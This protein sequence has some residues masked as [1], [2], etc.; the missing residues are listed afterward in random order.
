[1]NQEELKSERCRLWK[2]VKMSYALLQRVH[3]LCM[4]IKAR[5][6][7]DK[8][9]WE[10]CDYALAMLDGRARRYAELVSGK[11]EEGKKKKRE[12]SDRPLTKEQIIKIA[13]E[14]GITLPLQ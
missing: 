2:E 1:M 14:L 7:H 13:E 10:K 3:N 12:V 11:S 4:A 9:A 6:N 8:D 5:Y